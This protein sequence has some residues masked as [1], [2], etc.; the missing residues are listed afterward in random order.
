[1]PLQHFSESERTR[2][3]LFVAMEELKRHAN[4]Y[5]P[6]VLSAIE[7]CLLPL[8]GNTKSPEK[9]TPRATRCL[10]AGM[11]LAADL[12]TMTGKTII[13]AGTHLS[14]PHLMLIRDIGELL[15]LEE[16]AYVLET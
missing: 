15:G 2:H 1:M 9:V 6:Q 8:P 14:P 7:H 13:H 10:E 4:W 12:K 3:N 16:P 5:D 11:C